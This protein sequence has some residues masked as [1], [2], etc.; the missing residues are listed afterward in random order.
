M[1]EIR[2]KFRK[3]LIQNDGSNLNKGREKWADLRKV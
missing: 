2:Y 1:A 3:I